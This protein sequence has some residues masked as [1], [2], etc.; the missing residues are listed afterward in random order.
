ML[1]ASLWGET[2]I[3]CNGSRWVLWCL[4]S[5]SKAL[6]VL[7]KDGLLKAR[8]NLWYMYYPHLKVKSWQVPKVRGKVGAELGGTLTSQHP[9]TPCAPMAEGSVQVSYCFLKEPFCIGRSWKTLISLRVE[10][11]AKKLG[12]LHK[13]QNHKVYIRAF[14]DAIL[15]VGRG[16]C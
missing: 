1:D 2:S 10:W 14:S 7:W 12:F 15:T 16:F 8:T 11:L 3:E 5:S 13:I 4:C 6:K 9:Q